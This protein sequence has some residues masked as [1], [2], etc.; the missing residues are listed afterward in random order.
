[1][2]PVSPSFAG[3]LSAHVGDEDHPSILDQIKVRL[4]I[5]IARKR[6][7]QSVGFCFELAYQNLSAKQLGVDHNSP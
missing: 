4:D 1:M 5:S 6:G 7:A 3:D 2:H